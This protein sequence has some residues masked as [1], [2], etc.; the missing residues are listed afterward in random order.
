MENSIGVSNGTMVQGFIEIEKISTK[1]N[2]KTHYKNTITSG[3]KQFLLA[4]SAGLMLGMSADTFGMS[5]CSNLIGKVGSTSS[6][7]QACK[8]GRKDRDITNVLL[9]LDENVLT[10]MSTDTSFVN[11]WGETFE[12]ADKVVGYANN[13][14]NPTSDGKEGLIDFCNGDYMVDPYT[15]CKRWKYPEGVATGTINCIAMMPATVLK[16]TAGEGI[17]FSKCLDKINTQYVNYTNMST[18]F[19]IP[20]IP[21]YTGN[22]EILLNFKK[23]DVSR[24]KYN[25]GTGE[26]TQVP[27]TENFF[28]PTPVNSSWTIVDMQYIDNYLY[29]VECAI[30]GSYEQVLVAVYDPASSM[31]RLTYFGLSY[32]VSYECKVKASIFKVNSD[33]YVS[34]VSSTDLDSSY[35]TYKLYKLTIGSNGYATGIS[36]KY[37]DFSSLFEL[38]AGFNVNH[39]GLG[40]YGDNYIMYN[41]IKLYNNVSS[42]KTITSG[43]LTGYK[44]V[45]YV[46]T[47]ITDPF[48]SII[49]MIPGI[50]PNEILFANTSVK[51]TLRVGFDKH[52]NSSEHGGTYDLNQGSVV[53]TNNLSNTNITER[54][55]NTRTTGVYLTLDKWWTNIFSFVKLNTPIEKTD[56]DII[57]VSYGYKII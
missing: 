30:N 51:G 18:G 9:N 47:D 46:F 25:I 42:S 52:N 15:V 20:G 2:V 21:G 31:S 8:V 22:Q 55:V 38:P 12:S 1:D 37:L 14:L 16:D 29:V 41:Y 17:K 5:V 56:T 7:S 50:T 49:D 19:L 33:L 43:T 48:N 53:V 24:W 34:A 3:G 4:K 26:I 40:A 23:D 54:T 36:E 28:I 44:C 27:E 13:D 39:V 32:N 10:G 45:G 35:S 57:Y 6:Y 11:V